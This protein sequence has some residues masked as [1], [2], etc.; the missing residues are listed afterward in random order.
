VERRAD[1]LPYPLSTD[2][3]RASRKARPL[4]D[5]GRRLEEEKRLEDLGGDQEQVH[6][7]VDA[8]PREPEG[9][10]HRGEVVELAALKAATQR[11]LLAPGGNG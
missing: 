5:A 11:E 8:G 10:G 4:T 2:R 6:E 9:A 7:L 3:R 1:P